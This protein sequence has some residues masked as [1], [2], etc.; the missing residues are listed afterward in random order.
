MA[1]RP[2]SALGG[3]DTSERPPPVLVQEVAERLPAASSC[4]VRGRGSPRPSCASLVTA[5]GAGEGVHSQAREQGYRPVGSEAFRDAAVP[6]YEQRIARLI[7]SA[8]REAAGSSPPRH[9]S[10]R[11]VSPATAVSRFTREDTARAR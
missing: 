8:S 4:Q 3:L 2:A 9:A 1:E 10:W 5:V 7:P 6:L 11:H